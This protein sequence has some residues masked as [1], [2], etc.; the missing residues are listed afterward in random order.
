MTKSSQELLN[1][2]ASKKP[3]DHPVAVGKTDFKGKM[4][5][6]AAN[7]QELG[8]K[9]KEQFKIFRW[10]RTSLTFRDW[11]QVGTEA[12]VGLNLSTE[13]YRVIRVQ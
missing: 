4:N 6:E 7:K 9:L 5:Q 3:A 8:K 2:I 13:C 10:L 11:T 12:S 1:S